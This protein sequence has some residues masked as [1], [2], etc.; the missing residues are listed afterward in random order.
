[1]ARGKNYAATGLGTTGTD[2]TILGLTSAATVRPE[3]HYLSL[4]SGATPADQ[5]T[6]LVLKRYTAAGTATAVVPIALD[7][8]SPA[9]LAAAGEN[10]TVEPTYTAASELFSIP[11]NQRNTVQWWA[12]PGGEI[13]LPAT[14][15]NGVG[16][17][18][19]SSTGTPTMDATFHWQE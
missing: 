10:H 8:A 11:V 3:L 15:A 2:K 12:A 19:L 14:A 18:S 5:A 13:V 7:P 6:T 16:I 17:K 9:A 1:M 4:G